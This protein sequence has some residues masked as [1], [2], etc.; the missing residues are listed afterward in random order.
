M[1]RER[2]IELGE[3]EVEW[4]EREGYIGEGGKSATE[5]TRVEWTERREGQH[6]EGE[7]SRMEETRV[8]RRMNSETGT[9]DIT[10]GGSI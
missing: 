6:G 10:S 8:K 9:R 1:G 5:E 2:S 4:G 3:R 7:E